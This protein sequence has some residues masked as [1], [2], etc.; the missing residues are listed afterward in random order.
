MSDV[1]TSVAPPGPKTAALDTPGPGGGR[2][3]LSL[4]LRYWRLLALTTVIGLLLGVAAGAIRP[5]TYTAES[6][7][8]VGSGNLSDLNIPGFPTA[9][10]AMAGNYARWVSNDAAAGTSM[11]AGTTALRASPLPESNVIRIQAEAGEQQVAV[12]AAQT[13]A[14]GLQDAVNKVSAEN[15]TDALLR[16]AAAASSEVSKAQSEVDATRRAYEASRTRN[17]DSD[18]TVAAYSAFEAANSNLSVKTLVS[19]GVGDRYRRLVSTNSTETQ[20]TQVGQARALGGDRGA[21]MQRYG[22]IG[23]VLGAGAGLAL[24]LSA[25]RRSNLGSTADTPTA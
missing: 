18:Q 8:A 5:Q 4:L 14:T 11:P 20:V 21:A 1:S 19:E 7:M 22:L 25:A 23:L 24:S 17:P 16:E 2:E 9:S 13:A 10:A 15:D 12:D 3:P 6:R